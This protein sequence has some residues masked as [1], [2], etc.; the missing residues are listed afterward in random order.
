M[1]WEKRGRKRYYYIKRRLAGQVVSDYVGAGKAAKVIATLDALAREA[2]ISE[3]Q[4]EQHERE[5]Q[6]AADAELDRLGA[7]IRLLV[8]AVLLASGYH[9]HKGQWR[10]RRER[11]Q[12]S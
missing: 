1:A 9:T 12:D 3:R 6:E 5:A 8:A 2:Q 4:R 10:T 11:Q 7:D